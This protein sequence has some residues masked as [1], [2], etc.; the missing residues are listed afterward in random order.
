MPL[1]LPTLQV[2]LYLWVYLY[3][4]S[5]VSEPPIT[6]LKDVSRVLAFL[7]LVDL[8]QTFYICVLSG[9]NLC[10]GRVIPSLL[11]SYETLM[12]M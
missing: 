11:V 6:G 4:V 10:S 3:R 2:M 7:P 5:A 9:V 12:G 8:R 1:S